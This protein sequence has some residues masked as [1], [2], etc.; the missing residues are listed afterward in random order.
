[1]TRGRI[2]RAGLAMTRLP[3]H[4]CAGSTT[5]ACSVLAYVPR[6]AAGLGARAQ[7]T[8]SV[9]TDRVGSRVG[10]V[11]HAPHRD[12]V[13]GAPAWPWA[14]LSL[15]ANDKLMLLTELSWRG[16]GEVTTGPIIRHGRATEGVPM[17]ARE[18]GAEKARGSVARHQRPWSE[19]ARHASRRRGVVIVISMEPAAV[20]WA[21]HGATL[22]GA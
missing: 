16:G 9:R 1:M 8:L 21:A 2:A 15:G 22:T 14:A 17:D 12:C 4:P 7:A 13:D 5:A 6:P 18:R 11:Q 3:R 10:H 20:C 19:G